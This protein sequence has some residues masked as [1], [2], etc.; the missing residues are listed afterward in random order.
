MCDLGFGHHIV[1]LI[2][3]AEDIQK[4][5]EVIKSQ[6]TGMRV[7]TNINKF[8]EIRIKRAKTAAFS[9]GNKT[10]EVVKDI[11]IPSRWLG[12]GKRER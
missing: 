10:L 2:E 5:V 7:K 4:F 9:L 6:C 1:V 8:K 12:L 3:T 11:T